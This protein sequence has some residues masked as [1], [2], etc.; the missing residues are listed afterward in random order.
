MNR[1]WDKYLF[2]AFVVVIACQLLRGALYPWTAPVSDLGPDGDTYFIIGQKMASETYPFPSLGTSI[3]TPLYCFVVSILVKAFGSSLVVVRYF[4]LL[5]WILVLAM[6]YL[7]ARRLFDHRVAQMSTLTLALDDPFW[8]IKYVQYEL[9]LMALCLCGVWLFLDCWERFSLGTAAA[10]GC[11]WGLATLTASKAL[12]IPA[13]L[14]LVAAIT[15]SSSRQAVPIRRVLAVGT[16]LGTAVLVAVLPLAYR[17][18]KATGEWICTTSNGGLSFAIGNNPHAT[19]TLSYPPDDSLKLPAGLSLVEQDRRL[20]SRGFNYICKHPVEFFFWLVPLKVFYLFELWKARNVVLILLAAVAL[21]THRSRLRGM[22][23]ASA[24]A[25][26]VAVVVIHSAYYGWGRHRFP[27]LPFL[28]MLA[29]L[30]LLEVIVSCGAVLDRSLDPK[31][32]VV[33]RDSSVRR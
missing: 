8:F 6:A 15:P 3:T 26:I 30:P 28:H 33:E 25:I 21:V 10:C 16:V 9:L 7:L 23:V 11:M 19:G 29:A 20:Y 32:V 24:L 5:T 13:F 1:S 27:C 2:T 12:V 14:L 31:W 17:N 18:Y 4:N 22:H